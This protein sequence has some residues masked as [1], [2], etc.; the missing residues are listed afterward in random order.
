MA[1]KNIERV[2]RELNPDKVVKKMYGK[3]YVRKTI[4]K[5]KIFE[6]TH[7]KDTPENEEYVRENLANIIR[8]ILLNKGLKMT[9]GKHDRA[10]FLTTTYQVWLDTLNLKESTML[11]YRT[12][13]S[14]IYSHFKSTRSDEMDIETLYEYALCLH[15]KGQSNSTIEFKIHRLIEAINHYRRAFNL[16]EISLKDIKLSN[17][18]KEKKEINPFSES[19]AKRILKASNNTPLGNFLKIAF[20]TGARTNEIFALKAKNIDLNNN[21]IS[22]SKTKIFNKK[23]NEAKTKHS[24]R[25][26]PI[27]DSN[28]SV[29]LKELLQ[30]KKDDENIISV[31]NMRNLWRDLLKRLKIKYRCIY[32][33]RHTF[34][35]LMLKKTNNIVLISQILGHEDPSTT[36]DYYSK[37]AKTYD[38]DIELNLLAS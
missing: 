24:K 9:S 3:I 25:H 2:L 13:L 12:F 16:Q 17:F 21:S 31:K 6:S 37:Y 34:A 10:E 4:N 1:R 38:E 14:E 35:S 11:K 32:Q 30:N 29:L 19:E 7:L 23:D 18:G 33:T 8:N 5:V 20:A 28:L 15:D 26:I 27:L 36:L 22:I